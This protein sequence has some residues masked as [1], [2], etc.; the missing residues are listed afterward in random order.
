MT[1]PQKLPAI[2]ALAASISILLSSILCLAFK[3]T[4]FTS[5]MDVTQE[6]TSIIGISSSS[7]R[8][9]SLFYLY[10][11]YL[12]PVKRAPVVV[13]GS[14]GLV[15]GL[16]IT[17][18]VASSFRRKRAWQLS[19]R[20]RTTLITILGA[21][22]LLVT[23]SMIYVLVQHGR[24]AHFDPE[25]VSH[26]LVVFYDKGY[27]S[28][29]EWT[30]E[31]PLYV[32]ELGNTSMTEQCVGERA[33]RMLMIVLCVFSLAMPGLLLW[34]LNTTQGVV[35]KWELRRRDSWEDDDSE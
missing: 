10:P 9:N 28:L 2:L 19:F 23:I 33:S 13:A 27:F 26:K 22:A 17:W 25:Y 12:M 18:L 29:E 6:G 31:I 3:V 4:A 5:Y 32:T 30:C 14:F 15:I 21:N 11:K 7:Y 34:D 8:P 24:S 16:A 35:E 1:I 20:Q